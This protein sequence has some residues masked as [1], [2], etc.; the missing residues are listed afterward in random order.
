MKKKK[1][2][3]QRKDLLNVEKREEMGMCMQFA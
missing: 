1:W 3:E 2:F